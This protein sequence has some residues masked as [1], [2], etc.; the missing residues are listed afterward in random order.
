MVGRYQRVSAS[1]MYLDQQFDMLRAEGRMIVA[2]AML[3][4]AFGS[5]ERAEAHYAQEGGE[6]RQVRVGLRVLKKAVEGLA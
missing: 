6:M 4:D 2:D 3:I 5:V 1:R